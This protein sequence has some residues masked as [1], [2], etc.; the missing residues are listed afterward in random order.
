MTALADDAP[1]AYC[2]PTAADLIERYTTDVLEKRLSEDKARAYHDWLTFV[3]AKCGE[4]GLLTEETSLAAAAF[5]ATGRPQDR[6]K[7]KKIGPVLE[8]FRAWVAGH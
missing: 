3:L 7:V 4:A 8:E 5:G 6:Y 1:P 2:S